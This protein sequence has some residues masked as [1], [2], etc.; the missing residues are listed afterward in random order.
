MESSIYLEFKDYAFNKD[1]EKQ[2]KDSDLEEELN[3]CLANL[4]Q[5]ITNLKKNKEKDEE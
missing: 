1:L 4:K 5:L 2:D 3:E